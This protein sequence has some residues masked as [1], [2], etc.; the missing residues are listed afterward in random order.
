MILW[1]SQ[2]YLFELLGALTPKPPTENG[3]LKKSLDTSMVYSGTSI[4]WFVFVLHHTLFSSR[5]NRTWALNS[6]CKIDLA[7]FA[8]WFFSYHLTLQWKLALIQKSSAQLPKAFH[9]HG[10]TKQPKKILEWM[11]SQSQLHGILILEISTLSW[12]KYFSKK[13]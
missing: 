13:K 8:N 9:Q 3:I 10:K 4:D 1:R 5:E 11:L 2:L 6:Q 7:D 12:T